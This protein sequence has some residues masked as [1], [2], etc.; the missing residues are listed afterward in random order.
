ML[1]KSA[2]GLHSQGMSWAPSPGPSCHIETFSTVIRPHHD[3]PLFF[4]YNILKFYVPCSR[5]PSKASYL[6][7]LGIF[8]SLSYSDR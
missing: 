4:S 3:F 7:L 1:L 2:Q 6:V 5:M 8:L